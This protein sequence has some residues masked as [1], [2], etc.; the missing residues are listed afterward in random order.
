MVSGDSF[1]G[2]DSGG[3]LDKQG[4]LYRQGVERDALLRCGEGDTQ[5]LGVGGAAAYLGWVQHRE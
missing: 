5:A 4:N 2:F 1:G 3:P